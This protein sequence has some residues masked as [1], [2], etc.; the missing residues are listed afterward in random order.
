MYICI[1]YRAM[2]VIT[3]FY[4]S[5][6]ETVNHCI[7]QHTARGF[8]FVEPYVVYESL[9]SLVLHYAQRSL[10]DYN[11]LLNTT[12]AFPVLHKEHKEGGEG[13][14]V[15]AHPRWCSSSHCDTDCYI[16]QIKLVV[17]QSAS[18][19]TSVGTN[20]MLIL[21]NT[22]EVNYSFDMYI[23]EEFTHLGKQ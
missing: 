1:N 23:L 10:E 11:E 17:L 6:N 4:F 2:W 18:W 19:Q 15:L 8:G 5:C 21:K 14:Y 16:V 9:K 13:G 3:F 20:L 7:I 12:L 22:L